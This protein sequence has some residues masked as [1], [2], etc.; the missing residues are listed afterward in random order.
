LHIPIAIFH[1]LWDE[2]VPLEAVRLVAEE[3]FENCSFNMVDDDHSLHSTF[4]T[5]DWDALL[6]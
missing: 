6:Q 1:G 3:L 2:V 5:L 4:A